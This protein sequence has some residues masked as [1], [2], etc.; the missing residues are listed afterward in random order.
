MVA[1]DLETEEPELML[2]IQESS[3]GA[4]LV[5]S[6]H[7]SLRSVAHLINRR[8]RGMHHPLL[9]NPVQHVPD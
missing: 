7:R 4:Y 5:A 6:A 9:F 3:T 1:G 2:M 8:G